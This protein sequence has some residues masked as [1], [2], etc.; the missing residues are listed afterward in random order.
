MGL[1]FFFLVNIFSVA[2]PV[3][4]GFSRYLPLL[5]SA[6]SSKLGSQDENVVEEVRWIIVA[7]T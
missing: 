7:G 2:F 4:L 6:Y 3:Y 5:Y 1:R